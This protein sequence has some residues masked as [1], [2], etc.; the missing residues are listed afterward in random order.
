MLFGALIGW[1]MGE[2]LTIVEIVRSAFGMVLLRFIVQGVVYGFF[3]A[4]PAM[5]LWDLVFYKI[6]PIDFFQA[7]ALLILSHIVLSRKG[8]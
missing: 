2:V 8:T 5:L 6:Y 7:W 4:L 3:F 1:F